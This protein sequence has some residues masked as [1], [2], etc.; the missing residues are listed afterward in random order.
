MKTIIL[1]LFLSLNLL[2]QSLLTLFDS[3]ATVTP[4]S[5][6]AHVTDSLEYYGNIDSLSDGSVDI[7]ACEITTINCVPYSADTTNR[8]IKSGNDV[9]FASDDVMGSDVDPKNFLGDMTIEIVAEF[10]DSTTCEI[11]TIRG[12]TRLMSFSFQGSR[13]CVSAWGGTDVYNYNVYSDTVMGRHHILATW[14]GVNEAGI[15]LYVDNVVVPTMGNS[16]GLFGDPADIYLAGGGGSML[17]SMPLWRVY[18]DALTSGEV[19]TNY[20]SDSVQDLMP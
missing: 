12:A 15:T 8:P 17:F 3:G 5:A 10:S 9:W 18:S 16:F 13:F 19:T 7:W 2:A 6:N 4:P 11:F 1:F 20:N 14:D